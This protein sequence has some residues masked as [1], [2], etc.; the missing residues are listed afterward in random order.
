MNN[1]W[2][3]YW[4]TR[5]DSIISLCTF[6]F[7][8]GVLVLLAYTIIFLFNR[9]EDYGDH[10]PGGVEFTS[11]YG[12]YKRY[13]IWSI[14]IFGIIGTFVPNQKEAI[15]I[16]AG[17]KTMNYIKSDSSLNKLPYQATTIISQYMD[18]QIESLKEEKSK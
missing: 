18:K 4:L 14:L 9:S 5:L 13:A 16:I 11:H 3:I 6:G 12:K 2:S 8:L 7:S 1:Y 17:G 10:D 15:I